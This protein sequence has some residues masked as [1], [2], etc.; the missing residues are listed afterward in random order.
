MLQHLSLQG[1]KGRQ[2]D[3]KPLRASVGHEPSFG[4]YGS[5]TDEAAFG[6]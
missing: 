5:L 4:H 6:V 1:L 2:A 3:L